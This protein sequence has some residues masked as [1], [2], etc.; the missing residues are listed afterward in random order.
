MAALHV[1]QERI[2]SEHIIFLCLDELEKHCMLMHNICIVRAHR[3]CHK[4]GAAS[5][6]WAASSSEENLQKSYQLLKVSRR[7]AANWKNRWDL[8]FWRRN[9][10]KM[11]D[12]GI[13]QFQLREFPRDLG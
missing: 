7:T 5:V 8:Y 4:L 13:A 12:S 1:Y 6:C 10:R 9:W 11:H 2:N 3:D